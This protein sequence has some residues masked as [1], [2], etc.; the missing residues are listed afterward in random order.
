MTSRDRVL[1][2]FAP[3]EPDRVPLWCGASPGFWEKAK[4]ELGLDDQGLR[5]RLGDDF[6]QVT[7]PYV[8]P[9]PPLS[10]GATSGTV[11]GVERR[12]MG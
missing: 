5:Q 6:R 3:E 4:R 2:A 1:T 8:G 11:F 9:Q 10:P 7:G 12:G